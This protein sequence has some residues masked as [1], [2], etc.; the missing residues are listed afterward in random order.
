MRPR[1]R[2]VPRRRRPPRTGCRGTPNPG[3]VASREETSYPAGRG[4]SVSEFPDLAHAVAALAA[5]VMCDR[6]HRRDLGLPAHAGRVFRDL[7]DRAVVV[8]ALDEVEQVEAVAEDD[9]AADAATFDCLNHLRPH[10]PGIFLLALLRAG[11]EP[12]AEG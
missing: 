5:E 1:R 12:G 6:H 9:V 11:L 3:Q 2:D 4:R 10:R 8:I 7:G